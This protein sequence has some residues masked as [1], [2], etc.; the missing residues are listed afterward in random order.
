MLIGKVCQDEK[1]IYDIAIRDA[2]SHTIGEPTSYP[3][4]PNKQDC[5]HWYR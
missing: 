4:L 1:L 2:G 5:L 3:A